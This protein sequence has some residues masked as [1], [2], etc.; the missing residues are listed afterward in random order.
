MD[1]INTASVEYAD[2]VSRLSEMGFTDH[3]KSCEALAVCSGDLAAAASY[4]LS[5][6]AASPAAVTASSS[7]N[8]NNN[9][10][11]QGPIS[12]YS[13]DHGRSACT[14]IALTGASQFL[15]QP[16]LA[17]LT[18]T[19][20]QQMILQ[21][22]ATYV[23]LLQAT[24]VPGTMGSAPV[25]AMGKEAVEHYSAEQVLATN[26]GTSEDPTRH[27]RSLHQIGMVRQGV[28]NK[29]I[30]HPLGLP[31]M[32]HDC[33]TDGQCEEDVWTAVLITKT[34]ET[35]LI[36]LPPLSWPEEQQKFVLLDSHPRPHLTRVF[37]QPPTQAYASIYHTLEDLVL[38]LA[39]IF[40]LTLL[41]DDD[42]INVLYN[43]FDLY[44][45]QA[46]T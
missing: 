31:S 39:H 11:I 15:R 10:L 2:M 41:D 18:P 33:W 22:A 19:F 28:I 36:L 4:L 9:T 40:P 7:Y 17:Q 44:V 23:L 1:P 35:V 43:S 34:P 5:S 6:S 26:T 46:S 25:P 45:F 38:T 14:C 13:V 37:A 20:L 30:Q 3:N 29:D 12:Q 24:M 27:F 16:D 32:I 21:G 42:M 8:N